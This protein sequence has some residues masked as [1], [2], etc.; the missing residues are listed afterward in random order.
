MKR[1]LFAGAL[2][3]VL[4]AGAQST[5]AEGVDLVGTWHVI[6]HYKDSTTA[7][8]DAPRWGD[9]IWVIQ[10][11]GDRLRWTDY[12]IISLSDDSGRFEGRS[13][14]LAHWEPNAG[15][16]AELASGPRVNSRGSKSKSMRGSAESGWKS[17][18]KQQRSVS[19]ITYEEKWS[20][21]TPAKPRFT[22]SDVLGSAGADDAEGRTLWETETIEE[23][24][25]VLRGKYDR[26]GTRLGT[27]IMTRIGDVKFLSTEGPTPNEKQ[28][29]EIRERIEREGLEGFLGDEEN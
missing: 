8:P 4:A 2:F 27:F 13:R 6:A 9:R 10:Q 28:S 23:G 29:D 15:Q 7:N 3:W 19:F 20:I 26:D 24:G 22:R 14:V 1:W 11:E 25:R 16:R 18:G 5:W 12:P 21:D 17:V